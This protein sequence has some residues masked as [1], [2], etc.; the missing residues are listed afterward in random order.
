[1]RSIENASTIGAFCLA[2]AMVL[3][4]SGCGSH[5]D[6]RNGANGANAVREPGSP[7]QSVSSRDAR[8]V[9]AD[10]HVSA[11]QFREAAIAYRAIIDDV[12][13]PSE[14][15]N[16]ANASLLET[17]LTFEESSRETAIG[18][19]PPS[20]DRTRARFV[21]TPPRRLAVD[22]AAVDI[23]T[24][25]RAHVDVSSLRQR[26]AALNAADADSCRA[27]G[28]SMG[29]SFGGSGNSGTG[30]GLRR[31]DQP[32]EERSFSDIDARLGVSPPA[33]NLGEGI[34][35]TQRSAPSGS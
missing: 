28:Q 23:E 19:V 9:A 13:A 14:L 3:A 26:V 27:R 16:A 17:W 21:I 10:A 20:T 30:V 7:A 25:A 8:L 18:C 12:T 1:M 2:R 35:L 5:S 32:V 11:R 33:P 31:R 29:A 24:L 6:P 34:G 22:Q 15:R 4:Q